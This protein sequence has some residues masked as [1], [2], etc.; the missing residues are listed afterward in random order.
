MRNLLSSNQIEKLFDPASRDAQEILPH[1]VRKLIRE[2]VPRSELRTF[3]IP[4]GDDIST[5]GFDGVVEVTCDAGPHV[6][7]GRSVWEMSAGVATKEF[8][9]NYKKRKASA[10]GDTSFVFVT[11]HKWRKKEQLRLRESYNAEGTWKSVDVIDAIDLEEWLEA[12]PAA[13]RWLI[14]QSGVECSSYWEVSAYVD[15]EINAKHGISVVP[16]LLVGG[17]EQ[18]R[19]ELLAWLRSGDP[20]YRLTGDTVEEATAFIAGVVLEMDEDRAFFE[21]RMLFV[22]QPDVLN[23]F[24]SA[25]TPYIVVPLSEDVV[26]MAACLVA[27]GVRI[28]HPCERVERM[29]VAGSGETVLPTLRRESIEESLK[30]M[31]LQREEASA[32]ARESKGSLTAVLWQMGDSRGAMQPWVSPEAAADLIPALLVAEWDDRNEADWELIAMLSRKSADKCN[33]VARRWQWPAGPL[34]QRGGR[35][36]WIAWP[37]SFGR[38]AQFIDNHVAER[39]VELAIQVLSE[40]DP[41][42]DMPAEDRWLAD[43][44]GK[45]LK[46]SAAV[47]SGVAAALVLLAINGDRTQSVNGQGAANTVVDRVLGVDPKDMTQR[48]LSATPV[49]DDLAEAAPDV[50][51]ACAN[52]LAENDDAIQGMFEEGGHFGRSPHTYLLWAVERLAWS[53]DYLTP[54]VL[55]LGALAEKDP[56][57]QLSNRPA[58]SLAEILLGWYPSTSATVDERIDAVDAL[59]E[60]HPDVAWKTC[61]DLFSGRKT[62]SSPTAKLRWRDWDLDWYT[63]TWAEIWKFRDALADRLV[64]WAGESGLRWAELAADFERLKGATK[65]Q[66]KLIAGLQNVDPESLSE[67]DRTSVADALRTVVNHHRSHKSAKWALTEEELEPLAE[68]ATL[69]QPA[70]PIARNLW[71]FERFPEIPKQEDLEIRERLEQT[72]AIRQEAMQEILNG[73]GLE[74]VLRVANE[75]DCPTD[76]GLVLADM[77]LE[78]GVEREF[79]RA[80]LT[81]EQTVSGAP[82]ALQAVWQYIAEVYD[83]EGGAWLERVAKDDELSSSPGCLLNIA[84]A[85]PPSG[86][87]WD[88]VLDW[89][90][91]IERAY[92]EQTTISVVR[93]PA[94]NADR[95]IRSLLDGG[96]PYRALQV[97]CLAEHRPKTEGT[98]L[99]CVSPDLLV[100]ILRSLTTH[101][102][103]DERFP[104]DTGSIPYYVERLFGFLD[105]TSTDVVT[106]I[107]LEFALLPFLEGADRGPR[108]LLKAVRSSPSVFVSLLKMAY[109]A[110]DEA[111]KEVTELDQAA[112]RLAYRLLSNLRDVPGTKW[113]RSSE[114][115]ALRSRFEGDISFPVGEMDEDKLSSWVEDARRLSAECGRLEMCDQQIGELLAHSPADVSGV[116]P[117]K[118]VRKQIE[119]LHSEA[120]EQ[121]IQTGVFNKRGVHF[122]GRGG[123]Q[124]WAI[125]ERFKLFAGSTRTKW[126][127]T[128]AV[129]RELVA[130]FS[131]MARRE[132]ENGLVE[133]FQ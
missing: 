9:K 61:E 32:I 102:L 6:P 79:L 81:L 55:L 109:R 72:R 67:D 71:L 76:V 83:R 11:P 18:E 26:K 107:Q 17:R 24:S 122:R 97:A 53:A 119:A 52:R 41:A 78:S 14:A 113:T 127:R 108:Q 96:R 46:H 90:E 5:T 95:A 82:K 4:V 100:E 118:A 91:G 85:L 1:L 30:A 65:L 34:I 132:D 10:D 23:L 77:H 25:E 66:D 50:F 56:G 124:E 75:A 31:D 110:K 69:F 27:K 114:S 3:R 63:P 86:E 2:T 60:Q 20:R 54:A 43:I 57:G 89:G 131:R 111:E 51:I 116:W 70:D 21:S 130:S 44:Q 101:A 19:E 125:A 115:D 8:K 47:R 45:V 128:S 40:C 123:K 49:I 104:P 59:R 33:A 129:L 15:E 126:P 42:L 92:W 99:R 35:W 80:T 103:G 68:L 58:N 73:R 64:S 106:I 87:T 29:Q 121:G 28:L 112:A 84:L 16:S 38:L 12:C 105:T 13:S 88:T 48:W 37:Y 7:R 98:D 94:Q 22:R 62:F 74:G 39:F 36:D 117:S 120:L 133:E 93:N